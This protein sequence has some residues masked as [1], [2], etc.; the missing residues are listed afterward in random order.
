MSYLKTMSG[1][2]SSKFEDHI[3]E[4]IWKSLATGYLYTKFFELLKSVDTLQSLPEHHCTALSFENN[5]TA[6]R[7]ILTDVKTVHLIMLLEILLIEGL[8]KGKPATQIMYLI[9]LLPKQ[10]TLSLPI[11][12]ASCRV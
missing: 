2:K 4:V 3:A 11:L 7:Y 8:I 12:K 6:D 5:A 1:K 10:I 9:C